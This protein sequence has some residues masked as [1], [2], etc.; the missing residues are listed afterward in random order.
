MILPFLFGIALSSAP[1]YGPPV[2][3][4][5]AALNQ[6]EVDER[7]LGAGDDVERLIALAATLKS[8]DNR[9]G[10]RAAFR[11]VLEIDDMNEKA[12]KGLRH[13]LYD[14]KWFESYAKLSKYRREEAK[15]MKEE[16][17]LERFENVWVP[18]VDVPFLRMGWVK[19]NDSW[20]HPRIVKNRERVKKLE[21]SGFQLR[22][23]DMS[24]VSPDDFDKWTQLLWKCGEDWLTMEEANKFHS[25]LGQWWKLGGDYFEVY[26]TCK[27]EIADAA[28]SYADLIYP[29]LVRLFGKTPEEPPV[30]V[31]LNDLTQYNAFAAGD[32]ATQ[33]Q[34]AEY[35]GFSSLHH[36][37]FADMF[38]DNAEPPYIF[39]GPGVGY[40]DESSSAWGPHSV[41]HAVAQSY[42]D[43]I[44]RSWNTI[45]EVLDQ[46]GGGG[47]Q[48]AFGNFWKEKDIPRWLRYGA[49]S[50]VER[51]ADD[52]VL[53]LG[54]SGSTV[55]D[56][57]FSE[58]RKDGLRPLEEIFE[59]KLSLDEIESSSRM[60]HEAGAVVAYLTYSSDPKVGEAHDAFKNALKKGEG[61]SEATQAFQKLL[62]KREKEIRKHIGV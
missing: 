8:E 21:E 14:G 10:A 22:K 17:G 20:A 60:I 58:I 18:L 24:W 35:E 36:S 25:E 62:L 44:D 26:S 32:Q 4:S 47:G 46:S 15:R 12:H 59:F 6:G 37:F 50:Y 19:V 3:F 49:A 27:W 38:Y 5:V 33:R 54:K 2:A 16:H 51:Y 28:R 23:D 43:Q 1:G 52:R 39:K 40:W 30:F 31:V 34:G 53:G 55:R 48:G 29:E 42:C 56:W 13:H 11:R 41:R 45:S 57:A 7:I 61:V 9:D